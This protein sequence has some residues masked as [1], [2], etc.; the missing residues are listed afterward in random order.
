VSYTVAAGAPG[1]AGPLFVYF[2]AADNFTGD[3]Y[4]SA[5]VCGQ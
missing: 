1:T 3:S 5:G 4:Y 2:A